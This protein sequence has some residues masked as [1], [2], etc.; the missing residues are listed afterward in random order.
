MATKQK[1]IST[2]YCRNCNYYQ[3]FEWTY[4]LNYDLDKCYLNARNNPKID[5][6]ERMKEEWDTLR[7]ELSYFNQLRQQ[8]TF[9]VSKGIILDANL[10][11][12]APEPSSTPSKQPPTTENKS[13]NNN[14]PISAEFED[15]FTD[16]KDGSYFD[17]NIDQNLLND[18]QDKFSKIYKDYINKPLEGRNYDIKNLQRITHKEWQIANHITENPQQ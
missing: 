5:Y 13:C 8:A 9:V 11:N 14:S 17:F 7:P 18:L 3:H 15:Q 2:S 6:M 4:K 10:A 16:E 12:T 1:T